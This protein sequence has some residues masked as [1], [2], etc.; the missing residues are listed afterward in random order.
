MVVI[1]A[2]RGV[3]YTSF[4]QLIAEKPDESSHRTSVKTLVHA[5]YIAKEESFILNA[6]G[7]P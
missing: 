1:C 7:T 4:D 6:K 5:V 3:L 2:A